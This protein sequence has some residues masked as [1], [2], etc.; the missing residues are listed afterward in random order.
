[1]IIKMI[2]PKTFLE[3]NKHFWKE[4]E[5]F[6]DVKKPNKVIIKMNKK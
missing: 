5:K 3:K 6:F 1:M 2:E 4:N